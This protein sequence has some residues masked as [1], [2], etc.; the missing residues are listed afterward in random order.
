IA[1]FPT[2]IILCLFFCFADIYAILF[3]Q[4]FLIPPLIFSQQYPFWAVAFVASRR[5]KMPAILPP[6]K[7]SLRVIIVDCP[8]WA[9][10]FVASRR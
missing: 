1:S 2:C 9:V 5:Y 8:F 6:Y 10:A 7:G 4:Y 3:R